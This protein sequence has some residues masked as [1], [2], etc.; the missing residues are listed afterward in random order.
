MPLTKGFSQKVLAFQL[1]AP[2]VA[3]V[4]FDILVE[5]TMM[6]DRGQDSSNQKRLMTLFVKQSS[7]RA[8]W[9]QRNQSKHGSKNVR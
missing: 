3:V 2:N 6:I 5:F 1:L 9:V 8:S 4:Q 7:Q